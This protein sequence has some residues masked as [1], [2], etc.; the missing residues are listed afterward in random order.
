MINRFRAKN[1]YYGYD[2]LTERMISLACL[3]YVYYPQFR[4]D[5]ESFLLSDWFCCLCDLD[6]EKI[7]SEL[8]RIVKR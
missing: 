8:K 3:D 4:D 2:G 1:L 5:V 7:L 6:G